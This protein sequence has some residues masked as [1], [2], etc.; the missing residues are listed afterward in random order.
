MITTKESKLMVMTM[1]MANLWSITKGRIAKLWP[2]IKSKIQ[3]SSL[4]Q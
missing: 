1:M 4:G 2:T 3:E